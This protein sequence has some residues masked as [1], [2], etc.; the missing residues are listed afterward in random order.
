V[1]GRAHEDAW[2]PLVQPFVD[3][4]YGSLRGRVRTH[5]IHEHLREHL[6]PAPQRVV[7]VG[8]GAGDQS[9][10]LARA[11]HAVT[12]V[13]PSAAMLE[14]AAAR[15]AQES[16][17]VA[18]RVELVHAS[19]EDAPHVLDG[20]TFEAVLCHGVLMYLD[21]PEPL[22]DALCE[23]TGPAGFVSI[24]AKNVEV[25]A[26]RHAHEGDWAAAIAAFDSDRQVNGLGIATRGDGIEHL[27]ALLD[28]RGIAPVAWYGVRLF[29]DGWTTERVA[30]DE[31]DL[32]LQ[33]ELM[34][35]RRDPYRR[36]SRLFHL[37]GRRAL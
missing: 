10:P 14:R 35:S 13:D 8:G 7:D 36:L 18:G 11:G 29:T 33:A 23:L 24:V 6:E 12:I 2:A 15:L 3:D 28:D 37:I 31:E 19:G 16:E 32:V 22:L 34:A 27:S 20:A 17:Q 30:A 1:T 9:L 26:L 4:H 21:D 25:M 5:V